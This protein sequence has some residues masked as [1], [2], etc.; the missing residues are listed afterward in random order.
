MTTINVTAEHIERGKPEECEWCP[1]ALAIMDALPAAR[2]PSVGPSEVTFQAGI[3]K[4]A[5]IAL[6]PEAI[7]FIETFDGGTADVEP[8]TFEL[9]YPAVTA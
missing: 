2:V 3:D 8:F 4:W 7:D 5:D 1:V 6:P 9:D